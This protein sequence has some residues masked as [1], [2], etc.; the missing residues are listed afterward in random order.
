VSP[1]HSLVYIVTK[2]LPTRRVHKLQGCSHPDWHSRTQVWSITTLN[3]VL[4]T[5]LNNANFDLRYKFGKTGNVRTVQR[6]NEERSRNHRYRGKPHNYYTFWVYVC[7]VK[8]S[9]MPSACA[10]LYCHLWLVCL[11]HIFFTFS[12]KQHFRRKREV[13]EHKMCFDFLYNFCLK[14]FSF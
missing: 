12:Y 2:L 14:H 1:Q 11:C 9:S 8:L 3:S 7:S 5:F 4:G 10:V 13:I 6:N